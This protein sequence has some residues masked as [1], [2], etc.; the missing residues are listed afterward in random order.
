MLVQHLEAVARLDSRV[1]WMGRDL[2][3]R[4]GRRTGI[5]L[6]DE[7]HLDDF[8]RLY[9][10]NRVERPTIGQIVAER[11]A[12]EIW[13]ILSLVSKPPVLW[14]V[15]PFHPHEEGNEFSNRKFTSVELSALQ[16]LNARLL[17]ILSIDHIVAIGND[18]A[19][20]AQ[21]FGVDVVTV[22]H[23]SYGGVSEFRAGMEKI[24]ANCL[25]SNQDGLDIFLGGSGS[26]L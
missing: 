12:G 16:E 1:M 21:G 19:R 3:Y 9:G 7:V 24:Y 20:Y 18:A 4:G 8:F 5:A 15:F 10:G 26:M 6:T 22:R 2:G 13:R 17:R 11:T 25:I 23:P 14:N